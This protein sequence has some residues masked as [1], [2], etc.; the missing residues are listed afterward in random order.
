MNKRELREFKALR[1][2]VRDIQQ[3]IH[4]I[5]NQQEQNNQHG[6][7]RTP[8]PVLQAELQIPES[9]ERGNQA[10]DDRTHHLQLWLCVGTWLAF[11]AAAIYAGIAACQLSKTSEQTKLMQQEVEATSSAFIGREFRANWR[12]HM[13]ITALLNNRGKSPAT[14]VHGNF[15]LVKFSLDNKSAV[16][17]PQSWDFTVLET[18]LPDTPVDRSIE[19]DVSAAVTRNAR[20]MREAIRL[21]GTFGYFN[22]F[23]EI[24]E[25]ICYYLL[26]PIEFRNKAGQ[27]QQTNGPTSV[28]C[29]DLTRVMD[30][31]AQ[32][33]QDIA[34]K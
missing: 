10:R 22:G 31:N 13:L 6:Q 18:M 20:M 11:A 33:R 14:A 3:D 23:R 8:P 12:D 21:T 16:G 34:S 30:D 4:A 7:P 1:E 5:R 32:S 28:A 24:S 26:G 9:V 29:D 25:P 15:V 17:N 2:S 19:F 27:V